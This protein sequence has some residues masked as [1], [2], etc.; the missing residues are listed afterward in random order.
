MTSEISPFCLVFPGQGSQSLAMGQTYLQEPL[1][2]QIMA[3]AEDCLDLPL[4]QLI[5]DGPIAQLTRTEIAQPALLAVGYAIFKVLEA[6]TGCLPLAIAGHSLGEYAAL[7]AAEV[8]TFEAALQLVQLRGKL[9]QQA[10][11][12]TQGSMGAVLKADRN[13]LEALLSE[14]SWQGKVVVGNFNSPSQIVLSGEQSALAAMATEIRERKLGKL[15]PLKVSGAF[16]SP[17]MAQAQAALDEAISNTP[18]AP[19]RFPVVTNLDGEITE[20]AGDFQRKLQAHLLSP[21]HWEASVRTLGLFSPFFL[22]AGP[23]QVLSGLIR[24]T[25]PEAHVFSL[26]EASQIQHLQRGVF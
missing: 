18:F 15:V 9:M 3:R 12:A 6:Q 23:G 2:Q 24:Q 11:E 4:N 21:V 13:G 19:A 17:L 16:H 25:L 26:A 10:C 8:L 5:S 20:Q 14:P 22:E 7:A 1:Y